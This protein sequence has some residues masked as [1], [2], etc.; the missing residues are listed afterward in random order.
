[1]SGYVDAVLREFRK[2]NPY[3]TSMYGKSDNVGSYHGNFAAFKSSIKSVNPKVQ[4]L[5]VMMTMSSIVERIGVTGKVL[6]LKILF[7]V[8]LMLDLT[9]SVLV[10][11]LMVCSLQME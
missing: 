1:M 7:E 6:L 4:S 9:C 11:F 8:L 5:C 3:I 10:L 2:K